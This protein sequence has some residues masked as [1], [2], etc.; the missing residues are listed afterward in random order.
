MQT[1]TRT[2]QT[3]PSIPALR[4]SADKLFSRYVRLRDS[5]W[6][7][8]G[9]YGKCITCSRSGKVAWIEDDVVQESKAPRRS[10]KQRLRMV[11]G[12]DAGHYI[13]RGTLSL[14]F[15]DENVN[16]QCKFHCNK[17]KS[18]N[19]EKYKVALDDKYGIGTRKKLDM[20]ASANR[21]YS[22]TK[23]ELLTVIA[24]S[25]QAIAF[26]EQQNRKTT[27]TKTVLD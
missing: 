4:R 21:N 11:R 19:I 3:T 20:L 22:F 9:W 1:K 26:Y 24:D 16:L 2:K 27:S 13:S 25:N 18:G 5:S 15:D 6:Q 8:D 17:M 14:R 12:W 10:Y 7:G 23:S